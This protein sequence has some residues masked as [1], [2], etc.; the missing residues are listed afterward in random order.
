MEK[1]CIKCD[2]VK[3]ASEFNKTKNNRD[4]LHSICGDCLK[5]KAKTFIEANKYYL[6]QL[7]QI[8]KERL[9]QY[10]EAKIEAKIEAKREASIK[11][12]EEA[13]KK[14]EAKKKEEIIAIKK[15][16][17]CNVIKNCIEFGI[18]KSK[19]DGLNLICKSCKNK[20]YRLK[21]ASTLTA[22][23]VAKKRS[24]KLELSKLSKKI[25]CKCNVVK[26]FSEFNKRKSSKDGM[27]FRCKACIREYIKFSKLTEREKKVIRDLENI[28]KKRE[29]KKE[30][31]R[32][33]RK[34][35]KEKIKETIR[36]WREKN[37]ER[38]KEQVKQYQEANKEKILKYKKKY[39]EGN[40]EKTNKHAK[41]R[42][43]ID[44]LYR[45]KLNTRKASK[46]YLIDG[47]SKRT[48]EILG[49]EFK[50]FQ[51]YLGKEYTE[52]M[53]LDHIIPLNWAI[54]DDEV[55]TLNHYS[56][57]QIINAEENLSK[58]DRYCKSENLK[59]VLD[60]HNDLTKL[61]KVIERNSDK[62]K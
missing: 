41:S 40:K 58:S 35:N 31:G 56:N 6:K 1:K 14:I 49:M 57:F 21:R 19:K 54:N 51:N 47:K 20:Y 52:D 22:I 43:E 33:Y 17:K 25:C 12:K 18:D 5:E 60:N 30:W 27:N 13:R 38:I 61:N 4:G 26:N 37:K 29:K 59:K 15:C 7:R 11:R 32:N 36:K 3:S 53:H 24:K 55:Y 16:N 10:Y 39:K 48:R 8:N 9:K 42:R 34:K 50:A 28:K 2:V 45:L 44:S 23:Q 46:K 62:I